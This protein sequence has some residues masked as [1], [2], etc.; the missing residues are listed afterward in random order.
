MVNQSRLPQKQPGGGIEVNLGSANWNIVEGYCTFPNLKV[1]LSSPIKT[2][3]ISYS[4]EEESSQTK[5][6]AT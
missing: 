3:L 2:I 1:T 5:I 6:V 4:G